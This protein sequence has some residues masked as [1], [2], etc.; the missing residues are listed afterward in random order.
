MSDR[1]KTILIIAA[2]VVL[3]PLFLKI[4]DFTRF[5]VF[6]TR[7]HELFAGILKYLL[8]NYLIPVLVILVSAVSIAACLVYKIS[9]RRLYRDFWFMSGL[10]IFLFQIFPLA[11]LKSVKPELLYVYLV[12][13]VCLFIFLLLRS[14]P[15]DFLRSFSFS[16]IFLFPVFA[17]FLMIGFNASAARPQKTILN[18]GPGHNLLDERCDRKRLLSQKEIKPVW[19]EDAWLYGG[20]ATRDGRF[21]YFSD[22]GYGIVGFEIRE[23]GTYEKLPFVRYPEGFNAA[24]YSHRLYLTPDEKYLY[25][26]GARSAEFVFIDR[27]KLEVSYVIPTKNGLDGFSAAMD[28]KRNLIYGFPFIGKEVPVLSYENGVPRLIKWI[29]FSQ[30]SGWLIQGVYDEKRDYFIISTSQWLVVYNASSMGLLKY[31]SLGPMANRLFMIDKD[32]LLLTYY[33][34]GY[35]QVIDLNTFSLSTTDA[36]KGKTEA[37]YDKTNNILMFADLVFPYL[38]IYSRDK[39]L[40]KSLYTGPKTRGV[41]QTGKLVFVS[42]ACGIVRL[43]LKDVFAD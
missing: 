28:T 15:F 36:P 32:N 5:V 20:V 30:I 35:F 14:V 22:N 21:I 16:V 43:E 40:W 29:D 13:F 34:S 41:V 38:Y 11:L 4:A 1:K 10:L 25:Y 23:D 17:L 42:S 6:T 27:E 18:G 2:A 33:H 31:L 37:G 26:Y 7:I 8:K 9:K 19:L 24:L 39:F 12:C 3:L